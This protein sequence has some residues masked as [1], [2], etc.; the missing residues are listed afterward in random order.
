MEKLYI[1]TRS[2]L[3]PGAQLAQSCHAVSSFAT[4]YHDTHGQWV[5]GSN[6]IVCLCVAN[7]TELECLYSAAKGPKTRFQEPDLNDELTA[8]AFTDENKKLVQRLEL[9]LSSLYG[10]LKIAS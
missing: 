10:E 4:K 7:E 5:E 1:I 6:N 3:P 9:A 8:V 2:D